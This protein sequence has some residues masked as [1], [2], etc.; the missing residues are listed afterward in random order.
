MKSAMSYRETSIRREIHHPINY[1]RI[2][3]RPASSANQPLQ[4]IRI[5]FR[6]ATVDE[7]TITGTAKEHLRNRGQDSTHNE[8]RSTVHGFSLTKGAQRAN[9]ARASFSWV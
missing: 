5:R 1:K 2:M 3:S 7:N 9:C 4:S 6:V 8:E